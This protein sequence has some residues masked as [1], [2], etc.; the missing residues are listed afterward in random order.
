MTLVLDVVFCLCF[1]KHSVSET[2]SVSTILDWKIFEAVG[3]AQNNSH[4]Y[5]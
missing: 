4:G 5:I 3:S 1:M 2:G